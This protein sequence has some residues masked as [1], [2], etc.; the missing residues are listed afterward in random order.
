MGWSANLTSNKGITFEE[1]DDIV[2]QLPEFLLL[3][4]HRV[5]L[6][7]WGWSAA[8][9]IS[10]PKNNEL[11]ISGSYRISGDKAETMVNYLKEKLEDKGHEIQIKYC[12]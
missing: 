3:F 11:I 1:V 4:G 7:E 12:W 9:D 2:N 5:S 6:N 10:K 8:T